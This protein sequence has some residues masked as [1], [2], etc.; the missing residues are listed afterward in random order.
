MG[1]AR[2]APWGHRT[3]SGPRSAS[4]FFPNHVRERLVRLDPDELVATAIRRVGLEN[5]GEPP[6]E[7]ALQILVKTCNDEADLSLFG[8]I[9]AHHHLLDLLETRLR[10]TRCWQQTPEIQE[11]RIL[12][13]IFI[14]GLPRSGSTF[15]HDLFARD[16]GNRVPQTWEV[17]SPLPPPIRERYNSDPRIAKTENQLRWL[18]WIQPSIVNAH[19]VGAAL[20]QECIAITGYTFQSDEFLAMFWAPSY[21]RWL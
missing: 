5:F 17:M 21:E 2:G 6:Y 15:L 3:L 4:A 10:L 1:F 13:P 12:S 11:Q 20:P 8:R 9:A 16:P 7:E 19:P 14:T 18:R